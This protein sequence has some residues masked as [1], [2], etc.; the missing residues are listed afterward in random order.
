MARLCVG[1]LCVH[2]THTHTWKVVDGEVLMRPI[3]LD[4]A[5]RVAHAI[6]LPM[7]PVHAEDKVVDKEA[8][9]EFVATHPISVGSY[10]RA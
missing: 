6:G 2:N 10:V 5:A 4:E 8:V 1:S 9:L 7:P 3:E